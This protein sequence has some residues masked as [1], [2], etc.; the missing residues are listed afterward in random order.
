M[1]NLHKKNN[2]SDIPTTRFKKSVSDSINPFLIPNTP[3]MRNIIKKRIS[4]IIF[5]KAIL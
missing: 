5:K 4:I 1:I 3:M 2:A